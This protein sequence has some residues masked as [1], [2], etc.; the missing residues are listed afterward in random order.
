MGH[1]DGVKVSSGTYSSSS[2][3]ISHLR[4]CSRRNWSISRQLG[5]RYTNWNNMGKHDPSISVPLQVPAAPLCLCPFQRAQCEA[6]SG[7]VGDV[8]QKKNL[9]V[10]FRKRGIPQE[11]D[12]NDHEK[13]ISPPNLAAAARCCSPRVVSC[14]CLANRPSTVKAW[15]ISY[16]PL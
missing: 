15:P 13:K 8:Q 10:L 6:E 2:T 4:K 16:P 11:G 9:R 14:A 7:S 1:I 12:K 5:L 3:D